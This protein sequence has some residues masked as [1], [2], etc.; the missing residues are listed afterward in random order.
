MADDGNALLIKGMQARDAAALT[1]AQREVGQGRAP[2][3]EKEIVKAATDFEALLL[4]EM[5]KSMWQSVPGGGLISGSHEEAIYRDMLNQGVAEQMA[6][7]Q[8][9][10]I[11]DIIAKEMRRSEAK[12]KY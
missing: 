6:E 12:R 4:Q 2:K 5:L 3:S 9:I 10:G 11:K 8:S 1:S 7:T